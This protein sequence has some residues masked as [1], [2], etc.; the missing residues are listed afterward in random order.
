M[1]LD[2]VQRY[3]YGY[4]FEVDFIKAEA[5]SFEDLFVRIMSHRYPGDFEAVRAYGNQGDKKADGYLASEKTVFQ[6]YGPRTTKQSEMLAKIDNDYPGAR[7]HWGSRMHRWRFVH[8]D[9]AG[10]PPEVVQRLTDLNVRDHPT[11]IDS[12][13]YAELRELVFELKL[14][15]L[16]DLF[17]HAPTRAALDGLDFAALRPV[18]HEISRREP[19]P[20]PPLS[21]PSVEKLSRNK[22]SKDAADLLRQGRGRQRLVEEY[23]YSYSDPDF[24]EQIAQGFR[25]QYAD[26]KAKG[27]SPDEIFAEL[28][29]F[30]GGMEGSPQRQAAVLA[31]LSYFFDSCDIF[32]DNSEFHAGTS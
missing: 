25:D 14:N 16:E 32:E 5:Q 15:Q 10:L 27:S 21:A 20:A 18:L 30:A 22:I 17:G 12:L 28:Q 4:R 3:Y 2:P 8:N 29:V 24:G 19:P 26:L 6:C 9:Q 7:A 11:K 31:I 13:S 23:F 1:V